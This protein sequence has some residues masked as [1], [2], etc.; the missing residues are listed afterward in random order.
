MWYLSQT[1][2]SLSVNAAVILR[3]ESLLW[4]QR[5]H[6]RLVGKRSIQRAYY[7][8]I[9]REIPVEMFNILACSLN[10]S[11]FRLPFCYVS[12]N[13]KG[14]LISFTYFPILKHFFTDF[15]EKV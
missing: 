10:M 8:E 6:Q 5:I 2:L 4:L 3:F 14:K 9:C 12:G 7:C 15:L 11:K 13:K 1:L